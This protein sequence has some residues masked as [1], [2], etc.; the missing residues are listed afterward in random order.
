MRMTSTEIDQLLTDWG[1]VCRHMYASH[2]MIKTDQ[3]H[4][5]SQNIRFETM[6]SPLYGTTI[7]L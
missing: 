7:Y 3:Y 4:H 6:K 1:Q 5:F 2:M